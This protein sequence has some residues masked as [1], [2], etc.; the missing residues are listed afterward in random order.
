[1]YI[2]SQH[3]THSLYDQIWALVHFSSLQLVS[4]TKE[5]IIKSCIT[6]SSSANKPILAK[7]SENLFK[8]CGSFFFYFLVNQIKHK[9]FLL[10]SFPNVSKPNL[11]F[12]LDHTIFLT[13]LYYKHKIS[14]NVY[15]SSWFFLKSNMTGSSGSE[16]VAVELLSF[17]AVFTCL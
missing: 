6:S 4:P 14:I 11:I 17:T 16:K 2:Q 8:Y 1:M 15:T 13:Q 10:L 12:R 3:I 5:R 9:T 7:Y